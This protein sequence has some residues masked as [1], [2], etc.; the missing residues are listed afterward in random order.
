MQAAGTQA[1]LAYAYARLGQLALAEVHA[2]RGEM[3]QA[4]EALRRGSDV[5]PKSG[6]ETGVGDIQVAIKLALSARKLGFDDLAQ[7]LVDRVPGMLAMLQGDAKG[8]T[9]AWLSASYLAH[10]LGNAAATREDF[11]RA[12]QAMLTLP[13]GTGAGSR[14]RA[15]ETRAALIVAM[16]QTAQ[17]MA[18]GK[19]TAS[20]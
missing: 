17:T 2:E 18:D 3:A 20:R 13:E 7:P 11:A 6:A 9:H 12:Y 10:Q 14:F 1:Q 4:R 5:L 19:T 15:A 16:A 8:Q